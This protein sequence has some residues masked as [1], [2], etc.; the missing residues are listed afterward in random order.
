VTRFTP[1]WLQAGSYAASV[2]RRLIGALWPAPAST[3]CQVQAGSGMTVNVTAGQVAVPSQ[4]N[5]GSTLCSSD[6]A[7]PVAI[8]AS[9]AAG[10][11]RIDIVICQPR[12]N[13]LDGGAN[14][15][16]VFTSVAGAVA[17]SPA[18]PVVPATPAGAVALAQVYVGGGVAA[19]VA[20]NITD[21]RPGA[22]SIASGV[23]PNIP[24]SYPR[25]WVAEA[26]GPSGQTDTSS[27]TVVCSMVVPVVAGRRY[28]I[29]THINASQITA[30]GSPRAVIGVVN[31]T[32]SATL[33]ASAGT[34]V[35]F[36]TSIGVSVNLYRFATHFINATAT[37]TVTVTIN[38]QSTAGAL[39]F[40][41]NSVNLNA[42]DVGTTTG[43]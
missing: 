9:P 14:N 4:N 11:N 35:A 29:T 27:G 16:F 23:V 24:P 13:D 5:T 40:A 41:A 30:T 43:T 33:D 31:G 12:G 39:R 15:D 20:G 6:A 19:I 28:R 25:G 42:E 18:N 26:Q 37:G 32:G 36:E 22:L 10:S 7:E 3:G 34:F 38:G 8:A 1:Q 17:V 2:D 21:V